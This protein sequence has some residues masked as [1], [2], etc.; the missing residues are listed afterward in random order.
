MNQQ[1]VLTVE[2][3]ANEL[4]CSKGHIYHLLKGTV[5]GVTALPCL[6]IGR[7]KLVRR[8]TLEAW[9]DHNDHARITD[10]Q[11]DPSRMNERNVHV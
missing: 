7:R 4:R 1:D 10:E 8:A 11:H 6:Q 9:K 3:V 2:E 5:S